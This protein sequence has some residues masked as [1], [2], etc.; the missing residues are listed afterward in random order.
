MD[1]R[2]VYKVTDKDGDDLLNYV[3]GRTPPNDTLMDGV[4]PRYAARYILTAAAKM[5][6]LEAVYVDDE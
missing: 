3:Y 4:S 1:K 6:G 5:F 2:E